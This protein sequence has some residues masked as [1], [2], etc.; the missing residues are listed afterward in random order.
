MKGHG[1]AWQIRKLDGVMLS[2]QAMAGDKSLEEKPRNFVIDKACAIWQGGDRVPASKLSVGDRVYL[3]WRL[4]DG[5]REVLLISDDASLDVLK[6][7]ET[8]RLRQETKRFGM[9]GRL[10]SVEGTAVH[11]MIFATHWS[12]AGALKQG[13]RVRLSETGV[14]FVP[15]AESIGA[16]VSVRKNRGAYG[17]GVTDV[18]LELLK[19]DDASK[20]RPWLAHDTIHLLED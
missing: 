2:A 18:M 10:Q 3:R 20:L 4:R 6:K 5:K 19:P 15:K 9:L 12:Q 13:Q 14:G 16:K 8:A 7:Q 17:S 11:V 1:H